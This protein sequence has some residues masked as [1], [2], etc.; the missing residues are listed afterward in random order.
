MYNRNF[1]RTSFGD[2]LAA[3]S[4]FILQFS[5][6]P[7]SVEI[8]SGAVMEEELETIDGS[9]GGLGSGTYL[10]P[11]N[12]EDLS[13]CPFITA[14]VLVVL[15]GQIGYFRFSANIAE[16][17]FCNLSSQLHVVSSAGL[18]NVLVSIAHW[19]YGLVIVASFANM[20]IPCR[21]AALEL[22]A[23]RRNASVASTFAN[24]FALVG[25]LA[26]AGFLAWLVDDLGAVLYLTGG[27]VCAPLC[28]LLP[29][30]FAI[31]ISRRQDGRPVL[32]AANARRLVIFFVGISVFIGSF[33][34]L[35]I[36]MFSM[37]AGRQG[38]RTSVGN[39]LNIHQENRTVVA[40]VLNF[41]HPFNS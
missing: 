19:T 12:P 28:L 10:K 13:W 7:T 32:C 34:Q 1:I 27:G 33:F 6:H 9:I 22:F 38:N 36:W 15:F 23:V 4:I 3:I 5:A 21:C 26:T 35:I 20:T 16:D 24:Q 29:A 30:I 18:R 11:L 2:L 8:F 41:S 25:I 37:P 39:L 40:P 31:E 14:V 17:I